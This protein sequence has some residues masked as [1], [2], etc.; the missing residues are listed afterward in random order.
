MKKKYNVIFITV[1]GARIDRIRELTNFKKLISSGTFCSNVITYAPYTIAAM[2]AIFSGAYG[3]KTKVDNY[4]GSYSF[5]KDYAT[6]TTYM[7]ENGYYT[8]GDIINELVIPSV[9]FDELKVHDEYKD[10][11][12]ERHSELLRKAEALRKEGKN[13]FVYL[14]YSNIHTQIKLN[15]SKKYNNFSKEYFDKKE[16]NSKAYDGYLKTADEYLGKML[17][18]IENLKLNDSIIVV[19]SDHGISVGEKFGEKSYGAFCYDYTAKAFAFFVQPEI[20]PKMEVTSLIRTIDITPTLIDALGLKQNSNYKKMNGKSIMPIVEN[21][22]SEERYA[23]IESGNPVEGAP[24]KKPNIRAIRTNKWKFIHN[25]W[26]DTEELYDLKSDPNEENNLIKNYKEIADDLR[27]K[28]NGELRGTSKAIIIAAGKSMR[29]RPLTNE[30]PK[31]MLPIGNKPILEHAMDSLKK[32]NIGQIVI[33]KGYKKEKINFEEVKYYEDDIQN[34]ILSSLMY[35]EGEMDDS[36][37]ALYSDILFQKE[38]VKKLQSAEGDIVAVVDTDWKKNYEGRD[39]HP[40]EEAE[41]VIMKGNSIRK[42]G[43]RVKGNVS[44]EFIGMIKCSPEGAKIFRKIYSQ[45]EE[46]YKKGGF[47][48]ASEMK[49]A[50]LTDLLQEII[51]NGYNVEAVQIKG[52]WKEFDTVQDYNK[53]RED[54]KSTGQYIK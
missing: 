38:I 34:G 51:D 36:F 37:I 31:C 10:D 7:K 46:K 41:K 33:I 54:I 24:P 39:L 3:N 48:E 40:E 16:E 13:F 12:G 50:Y 4:Y 44:G 28:L 53:L 9:G 49:K 5:R 30:L 1:D 15:V 19:H 14:H 29:L 23:Y 27:D 11:L 20:F 42:I 26:N 32:T 2:H 35:A 8:M 52:G 45:S 21:R 6:I 18:Q 22:E 17:N 43:K 47:Q 25:Y